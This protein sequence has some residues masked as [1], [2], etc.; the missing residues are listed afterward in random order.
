MWFNLRRGRRSF[1]FSFSVFGSAQ[2]RR[3]GWRWSKASFAPIGAVF[4]FR[5]RNECLFP[6]RR[7]FVRGKQAN[8]ADFVADPGKSHRSIDGRKKMCVVSLTVKA[9][10]LGPVGNLDYCFR[11]ACYHQNAFWW[12]MKGI[13]G[14]EEEEKKRCRSGSVLL[15]FCAQFAK[16]RYR[17]CQEMSKVSMK[18]NVEDFYGNFCVTLLMS[19]GSAKIRDEILDGVPFRTRD[20]W[21]GRDTVDFSFFSFFFRFPPCWIPPFVLRP[22]SRNSLEP[23]GRAWAKI[24]IST[25]QLSL[26]THLVAS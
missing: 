5:R 20:A 23:N 16:M 4:A 26:T 11:K 13:Q 1:F 9:S 19:V 22:D 17:S 24:L 15:L 12:K 7:K 21:K 8:F 14:L 18:S 3:T 2:S 6:R 10:K 25:C